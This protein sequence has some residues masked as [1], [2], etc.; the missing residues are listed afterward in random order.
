MRDCVRA[1]VCVVN[2]MCVV[3]H[4]ILINKLTSYLNCSSLMILKVLVSTKV[5]RSSLFPTAMVFP[6]GLHLMLM[7][8]PLVVIV[9]VLLLAKVKH[10]ILKICSSLNDTR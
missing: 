1:R 3:Y 4:N 8:S 6:L 5:N 2:C 7:F 10:I 9:C